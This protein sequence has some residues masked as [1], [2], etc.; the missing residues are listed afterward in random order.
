MNK[1]HRISEPDAY[2]IK[3]NKKNSHNII[4]QIPINNNI[5]SAKLYKINTYIPCLQSGKSSG[6]LEDNPMISHYANNNI[7]NT[8]IIKCKNSSNSEEKLRKKI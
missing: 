8:K 1:R 4:N 2:K 6:K 5:N 7:I 3:V